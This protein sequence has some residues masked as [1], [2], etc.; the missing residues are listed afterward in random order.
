MQDEPGEEVGFQYKMSLEEQVRFQHK[1]SSE[2]G[3]P[4]TRPQSAG[5][6]ARYLENDRLA[7][8][9]YRRELNIQIHCFQTT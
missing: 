1:I 5:P 2:D 7:A 6:V 9:L 4:A 3:V 8:G